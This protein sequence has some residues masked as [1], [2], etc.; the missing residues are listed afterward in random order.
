MKSG[1]NTKMTSWLL[2][3]CLLG[4]VI[5]IPFSYSYSNVR[6]LS[7]FILTGKAISCRYYG[8]LNKSTD[9]ELYGVI[10]KCWD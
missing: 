9:L 1:V 4:D 5:G 6:K 10:F 7:I 8:I 2:L 3:L